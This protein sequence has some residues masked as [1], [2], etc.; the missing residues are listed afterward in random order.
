MSESSERTEAS[1]E[2]SAEEDARPRKK[3]KKKGKAE[4][5]R[6]GIPSFA[7]RFP[8]DPELDALV[9][10][11]ERGDYGHVRVEAPRLAERTKSAAVRRAA[12]ELARRTRPDPLAVLMLLAACLLLVFFAAWYYT[13]RLDAP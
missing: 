12:L 9:E 4:A 10:V 2:P 8:R 13:H 3:R 5:R 6:E 1:A 7:Q 11:F